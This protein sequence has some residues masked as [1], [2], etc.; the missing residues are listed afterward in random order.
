MHNSSIRIFILFL[1]DNK[2]SWKMKNIKKKRQQ[3][4]KDGVTKKFKWIDQI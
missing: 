1:I 4:E 3:R 2:K